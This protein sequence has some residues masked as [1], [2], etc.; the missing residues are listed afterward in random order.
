MTTYNTLLTASG[1]SVRE[2][3][4]FHKVR[5]DTAKS[6]SSGRNGTP[7]G[8]IDELYDLVARQLRAAKEGAKLIQDLVARQGPPEDIE[9]GL[10]SDDYEAQGLGWPTQTAH[11]VVIGLTIGLLPPDLAARVRVVPRG[12]TTATAAAEL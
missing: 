8:A 5:H 9:L 6:W 10:A 2:A 11:K 4:A 7:Y 1:L 12:T 3:A